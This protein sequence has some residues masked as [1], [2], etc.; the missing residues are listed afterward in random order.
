MPKKRKLSS[1]GQPAQD[2]KK[3]DAD[4]K[5]LQK[6]RQHD[7]VN[8]PSIRAIFISS[9]IGPRNPPVA[10]HAMYYTRTVF[11]S[12]DTLTYCVLIGC[13]VQDQSV[14]VTNDRYDSSW[15]R[16]QYG[17]QDLNVQYSESS[18]VAA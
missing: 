9:V 8:R 16:A 2:E 1:K 10:L 14:I 11:L 17:T 12:S 5:R 7:I 13:H 4:R 15:L 18:V 3:R 6:R